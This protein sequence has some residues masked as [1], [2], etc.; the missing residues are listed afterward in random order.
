MTKDLREL[1][2]QYTLKLKGR[3]FFLNAEEASVLQTWM[4]ACP[5][6]EQ[7]LRLLEEVAT[8]TLRNREMKGESG[9]LR[10]FT[11]A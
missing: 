9:S 6:C 1:I 2:Y 11:A 3:G 7:L 4:T 5:D 8:L 10:V